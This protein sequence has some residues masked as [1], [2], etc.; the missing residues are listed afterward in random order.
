MNYNIY[1]KLKEIE[2][3]LENN[4]SKKWMTIKEAANWSRLSISTI[5]RA[6]DEGKLKAS[7]STGKLLFKVNEIERWLN[8][9]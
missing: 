8:G 3:Y 2:K 1:D 9:K 6:V 4:S 5:R 7:H